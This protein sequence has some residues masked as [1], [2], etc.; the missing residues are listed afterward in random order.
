MRAAMAGSHAGGWWTPAW[1]DLHSAHSKSAVAANK[2]KPK[3][4][5][6]LSI[7]SEH[8]FSKW[9]RYN[10]FKR[11]KKASSLWQ[12]NKQTYFSLTP[13]VKHFSLN[14]TKKLTRTMPEV[15]LYPKYLCPLVAGC[16]GC[17]HPKDNKTE[18]TKK[19]SLQSVSTSLTLVIF[20]LIIF[21][22]N[23][24]C[25]KCVVVVHVNKNKQPLATSDITGVG[26]WYLVWDVFLSVFGT[27]VPLWA[28]RW[29]II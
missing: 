4:V 11:R 9:T 16:S 22:L 8:A 24:Q 3:L 28:E 26:V 14:F 12:V 25:G 15:K 23:S 29:D 13:S 5:P 2:R 7:S 20:L 27:V 1:M 19:V 10:N 18:S 6:E 17:C 21:F